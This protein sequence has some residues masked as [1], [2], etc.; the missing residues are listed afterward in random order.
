MD[1][2]NFM[3]GLNKFPVSTETFNFMQEQIYLVARFA[4]A[5]GANVIIT[6]PIASA[7]GL[8]I[9]DGELLPLKN[10]HGTGII[11]TE[12]FDDVTAG[13]QTFERART[14]RCARYALGGTP[15][16]SFTTL[17]NMVQLMGRILAIENSYITEAA[18]TALVQG[19]QSS[20][21]GLDTRVT[22]I[23]NTCATQAALSQALADAAKHHLPKHSV[24]D[25]Y[26]SSL[27]VAAVPEGFVPCGSFIGTLA[28]SQAWN[29]KYP[30]TSLSCISMDGDVVAIKITKAN[31]VIIPDLTDRFIVQAGYNYSKGDYG[32][33]NFVAL[34]LAQMPR[35]DHGGNTG[36]SGQH[37]HELNLTLGN[38]HG[39]SDDPWADSYND[40]KGNGT[41]LSVVQAGAHT[42]TITQQGSNEAHEN[43]PPYFALYKLIKVI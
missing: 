28:E 42:H 39:H 33:E 20:I 25:W 2:Q 27:T 35:H 38:Y 30:D 11:V 37:S 6:P 12:T 21:N 9:V 43:R 8:V 15:L 41:R 5:I 22:N 23:Q 29:S 14:K 3:N 24:I 19:L 34:T 36:I 40:V 13:T 4:E 10:G 1:K 26:G 31:G 17:Q 7:D 18:V 16:S 32:G